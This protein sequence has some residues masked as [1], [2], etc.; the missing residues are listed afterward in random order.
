M[1]MTNTTF[2]APPIASWRLVDGYL[3][4]RRAD[5]ATRLWGPWETDFGCWAEDGTPVTPEWPLLERL[6]RWHDPAGPRD[7]GWY[8]SRA[9]LAAY[10]SSV[11]A[12]VRLAVSA[13]AIGQWSALVD[14]WRRRCWVHLSP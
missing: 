8:A 13:V 10:W 12:S 2:P 9:A 5:G 6:G 14:A 1:P 4:E 7:D 11:P 3:V